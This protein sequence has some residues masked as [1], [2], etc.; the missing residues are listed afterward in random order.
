MKSDIYSDGECILDIEKNLIAAGEWS[1]GVMK[2][3]KNLTDFGHFPSWSMVLAFGS[4]NRRDLCLSRARFSVRAIELEAEGK[5]DLSNTLVPSSSWTAR[6]YKAEG[7]N[8]I[9]ITLGSDANGY[10]EEANALEF[11]QACHAAYSLY[12]VCASVHTLATM[13]APFEPDW[14][15]KKADIINGFK[16]SKAIGDL[17]THGMR[18]LNNLALKEQVPSNISLRDP[19]RF[20]KE[21]IGLAGVIRGCCN[22]LAN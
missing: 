22:Y 16:S 14:K 12:Y 19:S 20:D 15:E 5:A 11:Y 9:E 6:E 18:V 3:T 1:F 17:I 4:A 10:L 7:K 2:A 8:K 13:P 21:Y